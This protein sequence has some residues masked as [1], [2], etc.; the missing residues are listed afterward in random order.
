MITYLDHGEYG[1]EAHTDDKD[2]EEG[3]VGAGM[4]F[5]VEDGEED[6]ARSTEEGAQDRHYG[7]RTL[8]T[9]HLR[10]QPV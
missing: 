5:R 7:E 8:P 1:T 9:A 3:A 2:E 10:N 6:E 4:A